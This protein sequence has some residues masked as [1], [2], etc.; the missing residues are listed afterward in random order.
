VSESGEPRSCELTEEEALIREAQRDPM[1]FGVLYERYVDRMYS[2]MYHRTGDHQEAEDLTS[3]CFLRALRALPRYELRGAPFSAWLYRIA[4]N[5]VVNWYRGR[6][7]RHLIELS[8]AVLSDT[9]QTGSTPPHEDAQDGELAWLRS[10]IGRLAA[11]RQELLILKLSQGLSNAEIGQIMGRSE[12]AI[13]QLYYRTL[14]ALCRDM[15]SLR[16]D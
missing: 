16:K 1:A 11:D 15:E 4:H 5:L 6:S 3:R 14:Q 9:S 10:A 8:D 2:Y 7:Q 13:K 12:G